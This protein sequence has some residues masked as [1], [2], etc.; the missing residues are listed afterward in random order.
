MIYR[1]SA[2]KKG[3]HAGNITRQLSTVIDG[4]GGG[5]PHLGQGGGSSLARFIENRA[6]IKA[7]VRSQP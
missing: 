1:E 5:K 7:I 4:G 2:I 3:Y 6:E